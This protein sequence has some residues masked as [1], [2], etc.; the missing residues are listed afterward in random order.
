M[1]NSYLIILFVIFFVITF[2]RIV[3][4]DVF[5]GLAYFM[6]F[7]YTIFTQ[8]G[9]SFFPILS[10]SIKAYF[11]EEVFVNYWLF[12]FGS[13]MLFYILFITLFRNKINLITYRAVKS[14]SGER[15]F[16][17]YLSMLLHILY[18]SFYLSSHW[19]MIS[20]SN[21]SND[22]FLSNQDFFYFIFMFLFK[23][24]VI[25]VLLLYCLYRLKSYDN[26]IFK[27]NHIALFLALE[28]TIFILISYK[29]G[30][31][32]D[33]LALMLGLM[34]FELKLN[35]ITALKLAKLAI[36]STLCLGLIVLIEYIRNDYNPANELGA[37]ENII[38][39]DYFAPS[40]ILI[41]AMHFNFIDLYEVLKSN[42]SN[43]LV[44]MN[45]PFLQN[46]VA[47]L[48]NPGASTR[49]ASYAF[50]IFSEGYIAIGWFGIF[51]NALVAML[52]LSFWRILA[53]S[54]C[55]ALNIFTYALIS[56][57]LANITRSQ[58]AYF[59]KIFYMFFIPAMLLFFLA[60]G[61]RPSFR[62]KNDRYKTI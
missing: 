14:Q 33:P 26:F 29:I 57:Q 45:Y 5:F 25:L 53:Q 12:V 47:D 15:I 3:K 37:L 44:R 56:T 34:T 8:I 24:S 38:L 1:L 21:A 49:S 48:F 4:L 2:I 35:K 13:F 28:L 18:T 10:I 17:F 6:L 60:T 50:Y 62:L 22:I 54:N 39:K 59:I 51:Y 31:R 55:W 43:A 20:Y 42:F 32:T 40:H 23:I 7:I 52:G 9:Y 46:T 61:Y 58:S 11:G 41:A 30:S 36:I 19:S 27:R 16:I